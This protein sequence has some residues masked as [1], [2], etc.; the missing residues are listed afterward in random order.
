M[1]VPGGTADKKLEGIYRNCFLFSSNVFF[2]FVHLGMP[3]NGGGGGGMG[4]NSNSTAKFKIQFMNSSPAL[5]T[6]VSSLFS[7][8]TKPLKQNMGEIT[9]G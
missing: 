6:L 2:T 3:F 5:A 8:K 7:R 9:V 1:F 4:D